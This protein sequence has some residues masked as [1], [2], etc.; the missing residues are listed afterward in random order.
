[1]ALSLVAGTQSCTIG[2]QIVQAAYISFTS[3]IEAIRPHYQQ[4]NTIE[5]NSMCMLELDVARRK[6]WLDPLPRG[7]QELSNLL[8]VCFIINQPRLLATPKVISLECL[9][10]PPR[11]GP[12]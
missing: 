7:V 12:T 5:I 6:S 8:V 9:V 3:Y 1:M 11:V 2:W 10:M 4:L